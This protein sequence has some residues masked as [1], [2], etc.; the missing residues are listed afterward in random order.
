MGEGDRGVVRP[1]RQKKMVE[2]VLPFVRKG[3]EEVSFL[4]SKK[5]VTMLEYPVG[6]SEL[7]PRGAAFKGRG[8]TMPKVVEKDFGVDRITQKREAVHTSHLSMVPE[9]GCSEERYPLN[10]VY[11]QSHKLIRSRGE[12]KNAMGMT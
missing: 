3:K 5:Q 4:V 12:E 11:R 8:F 7:I 10:K 2:S 6:C 9:T 1:L